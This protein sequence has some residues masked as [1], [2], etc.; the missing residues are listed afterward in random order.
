MSRSRGF[1]ILEV[2]VVVALMAILVVIVAPSFSRGTIKNVIVSASTKAADILVEARSS[3]MSGRDNSRY[4]VHFQSTQV[5]L[6]EGASYSAVDTNNLVYALPG[7][8]T[9]STISISGGGADIIFASHKGIPVQTGTITFTDT[10]GN[11]ASV[12]VNAAGMIDVQ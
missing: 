12:V 10:G 1:T 2:M 9:A 4:G 5:T 8:V 3:A 11:S 6:F 7:A